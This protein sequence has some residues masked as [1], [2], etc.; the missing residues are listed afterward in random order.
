VSP[1]PAEGRV[2]PRHDHE[3][4][5]LSHGFG[6]VITGSGGAVLGRCQVT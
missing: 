3:G 4:E 6:V 5:F 2:P 1:V